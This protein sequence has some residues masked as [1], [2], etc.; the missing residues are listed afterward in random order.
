MESLAG[1]L[2]SRWSG[3]NSDHCKPGGI[4]AGS[5]ETGERKNINQLQFEH[6]CVLMSGLCIC[7][8]ACVCACVCTGV[9]V[10]VNM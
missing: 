3:S 4:T 1:S 9:H 5:E 2:G 8:C 7:K 10:C 6:V